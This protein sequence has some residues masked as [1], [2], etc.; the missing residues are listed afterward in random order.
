MQTVLT[1]LNNYKHFLESLLSNDLIERKFEVFEECYSATFGLYSEEIVKLNFYSTWQFRGIKRGTVVKDSLDYFVNSPD[2]LDHNI[3][4]LISFL[5][6]EINRIEI[7]SDS[8][9]ELFSSDNKE[10]RDCANKLGTS[11]TQNYIKTVIEVINVLSAL[12]EVVQFG[13]ATLK[14]ID[15]FS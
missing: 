15:I 13:K 6:E 8:K 11:N 1:K 3:N 9:N 4:T 2:K 5:K 10:L 12:K 14:M 7:V